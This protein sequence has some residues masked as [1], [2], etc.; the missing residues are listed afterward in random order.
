MNNTYLTAPDKGS[1]LV[2]VAAKSV[3]GNT[4]PETQRRTA[5]LRIGA[6]LCLR[7]MA[8]RATGPLRRHGIPLGP[9]V[10]RLLYWLATL[11]YHQSGKSPLIPEETIMS[12]QSNLI[13]AQDTFNRASDQSR[14][15]VA[16]IAGHYE[17]QSEMSAQAA[18]LTWL[19]SDLI[20]QMDDAYLATL[21]AV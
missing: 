18:N 10:V 17:G 7:F 16:A 15:L 8:G 6:F 3:T 13:D 2:P 11:T 4:T 19:L 21:E 20:K 14:A 1:K 9:W 12:N 5:P